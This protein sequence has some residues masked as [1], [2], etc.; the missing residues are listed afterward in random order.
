MLLC[1]MCVVCALMFEVMCRVGIWCVICGVHGGSLWSV[2]VWYMRDCVLCGTCVMYRFLACGVCVVC[3]VCV[4]VCCACGC[5]LSGGCVVVCV[6]RGLLPAETCPPLPLQHPATIL[7]QAWADCLWVQ[8][9]PWHCQPQQQKP[10]GSRFPPG[11]CG[12]LAMWE[13]KSGLTCPCR[14]RL[15]A[16]GA[17]ALCPWPVG[18]ALFSR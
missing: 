3:G 16:F 15:R 8:R 9:E 1:G 18:A 10:L 6:W 5:V 17:L 2:C 7:G 4:R 14:W 11:P 12:S 13:R